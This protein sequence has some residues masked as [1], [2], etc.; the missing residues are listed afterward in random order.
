MAR[1]FDYAPN[2][3]YAFDWNAQPELND[4]IYESP[5]PCRKGYDCSYAGVCSFV[6][7]GE[8]GLGRRIFPARSEGEKDVVRI[9][10]KPHKKATFYERRR[11]RLSWPQWCAQM[12]WPAPVAKASP[13]EAPAPSHKRKQI[14]DLSEPKPAPL[15]PAPQQSPHEFFLEAAG[16]CAQRQQPFGLANWA[17]YEGMLWASKQP[18]FVSKSFRQSYGELLFGQV[19]WALEEQ[20]EIL[21][22]AGVL[23]AKTTAGKIVGMFMDAYDEEGLRQLYEDKAQLIDAIADAVV[24]LT[25]SF[26]PLPSNIASLAAASCM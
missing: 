14:L 21:L 11:L 3:S 24:L 8:E 16:L 9:F 4:P 6:H 15:P 18:P 5:V 20:R 22:E 26:P 12:G 13:V 19:A 1:I 17:A 23:T 10:G 2:G 25:D 7:P